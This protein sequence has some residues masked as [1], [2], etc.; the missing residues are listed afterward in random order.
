LLNE[1]QKI[2]GS[3]AGRGIMPASAYKR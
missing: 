2:G 1:F 3:G